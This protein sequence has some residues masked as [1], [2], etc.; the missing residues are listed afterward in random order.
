MTDMVPLGGGSVKKA[1]GLNGHC[2][3][4]VALVAD[5]KHCWPMETII[6]SSVRLHSYELRKL[7]LE[8]S[9]P[10]LFLPLNSMMT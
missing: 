2:W 4:F 1:G 5:R 7:K 10:Y 8:L 6:G 9:L 3:K